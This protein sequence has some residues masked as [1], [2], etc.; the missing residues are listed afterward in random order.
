M[1]GSLMNISATYII[2]FVLFG[3]LLLHMGGAAFFV[4]LADAIAG[5]ARGGPG[6]GGGGGER[7]VRHHLRQPDRQRRYQR[8]LHHPDDE[9]ASAS[10]PSSPARWSCRPPWAGMFMPPVMAST[11]FL[12][13]DISGIPYVEIIVAAFIPACL[14]FYTVF[15][16]VHMES[17]KMGIISPT[18]SRRSAWNVLKEDGHFIVP[19]VVIVW[20]L[21]EGYTPIRAALVAIGT[22]LVV[23]AAPEEGTQGLRQERAQGARDRRHHHH[24]R[25]A[26]HRR[27][28]HHGHGHL[29]HRPRRQVRLHGDALLRRLPVPG[30]GHRHDRVPGAGGAAVG[31]RHLY[32]DGHH[33]RARDRVNWA[34]RPW[35]RTCSRCTSRSSRPCRRPRVP[36]CSLPEAWLEPTP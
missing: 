11:V 15:W 12:M 9:A 24:H 10:G 18:E 13:S 6:Q 25:G 22:L 29:R 33:D 31:G 16:Q 5:R 35:P 3:Q 20:V 34:C 27:R 21:L 2:L 4:D 23:T 32:P 19:L 30:P 1:W 7:A 8:L 26:A 36:P 28:R 17:V 14:Y